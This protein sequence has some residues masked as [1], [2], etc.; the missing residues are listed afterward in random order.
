MDDFGILYEDWKDEL[1]RLTAVLRSDALD[2]DQQRLRIKRELVLALAQCKQVI[3]GSDELGDA[4]RRIYEQMDEG[5]P[6]STVK[7]KGLAR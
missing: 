1:R 7:R 5:I 3:Q 6:A 2:G 4:M